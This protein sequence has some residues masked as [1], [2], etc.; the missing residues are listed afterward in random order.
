VVESDSCFRYYHKR[1]NKVESLKNN[2]QND[3]TPPKKPWKLVRNLQTSSS[4][5]GRST[6]S[7]NSRQAHVRN[8]QYSQH[9]ADRRRRKRLQTADRIVPSSE[10]Q[11]QVEI[12]VCD[13]APLLLWERSI[14]WPLLHCPV[15]RKAN[16]ASCPPPK[17]LSETARSRLPRTIYPEKGRH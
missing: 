11:G 15:N 12:Q 14:Q 10:Y 5:F 2:L 9:H 8:R 7:P 16:F 1:I 13:A 6:R 17:E 3:F 4:S